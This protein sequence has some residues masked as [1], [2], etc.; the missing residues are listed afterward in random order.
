MK[1]E[2]NTRL[3]LWCKYAIQDLYI[4][5]EDRICLEMPRYRGDEIVDL[6]SKLLN[7]QW[8]GGVSTYSGLLAF[9]VEVLR[10]TMTTI[11]IQ[12]IEAVIYHAVI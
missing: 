5:S 10:R 2:N 6:R 12:G 9:D 8:D 1:I 11:S 7:R 4:G 3:I